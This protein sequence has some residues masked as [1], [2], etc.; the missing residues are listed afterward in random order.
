MV[1]HQVCR[2][3]RDHS[4][5]SQDQ[6]LKQSGRTAVSVGE[7]V[8]PRDVQVREQGTHDGKCEGIAPFINVPGSGAKSFSVEP[9][10]QPFEQAP[11]IPRWRADVRTDYNR[12]GADGA[13]CRCGVRIDAFEY[14]LI[15]LADQSSA[16]TEF[17]V[18]HDL[19]V[20]SSERFEDVSHFAFLVCA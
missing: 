19:V 14:P 7:R 20:E 15:H 9:L 11:A 16:K 18:F 5:T 17:A 10:S 4:R 1:S 12:M 3:E 13:G 8:N 6:V 2:G